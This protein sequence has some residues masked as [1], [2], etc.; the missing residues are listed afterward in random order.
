MPDSL[1]NTLNFLQQQAGLQQRQIPAPS[2][3]ALDVQQTHQNPAQRPTFQHPAF[4][5]LMGA[6][7]AVGNSLAGLLGG[8]GGR[9]PVMNAPGIIE[10]RNQ[11]LMDEIAKQTQ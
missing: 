11:L 3:A 7:A 6:P 10:Q 5:A 4:K 2:Q 1:A 9:A 8:G